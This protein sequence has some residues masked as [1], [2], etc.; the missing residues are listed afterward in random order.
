M[1]LFVALQLPEEIQQRV[2]TLRGGIPEAKWIPEGN[3]HITLSFLGE[4]PNS[5]L[6]DIGAALGRIR[7]PEFQINLEGVDV[8]GNNKRARILWAGVST[9][10]D[11]Q[12]LQ[13][14][15]A[16]ALENAGFQF[17]DRRFKPHVTLARI[18]LSSYERVRQYLSDNALFKT[19]QVPIKNF[20]LFSSHLAHSGAIH[21][22]EI[23]FDLDE[24]VEIANSI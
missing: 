8:F 9:S 13:Q 14:K 24:Q 22:E 12:R 4:V 5:E 15:V 21:T 1:R 17:E 16:T 2:A 3:A 11:L 18:H 10:E 23:I 6:P 7:H 19:D 20:T